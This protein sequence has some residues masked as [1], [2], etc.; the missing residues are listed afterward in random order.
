[1]SKIKINFKQ[2]KYVIP[3]L[4]YLPLLA[5]V[6]FV[7]DAFSGG[8]GEVVDTSLE[9]TDYYNDKLPAAHVDDIG[10]KRGNMEKAFQGLR[11]RTAVT[12]DGV[13]QALGEG[14]QTQYTEAQID[15]MNREEA[16][17]KRS[18]EAA[19]DAARLAE[20]Q[21]KARV[22]GREAVL[23][24]PDPASSL[25]EEDRVRRS[26]ASRQAMFD[27]LEQELGHV[28]STS[29]ANVLADYR[30]R[31]GL[32]AGS[33]LPVVDPTVDSPAADSL[34]AAVQQAL[35]PR[36]G[37]YGTDTDGAVVAPGDDVKGAV[38][39]KQ[40]SGISDRFNTIVSDAG[41]DRLI[42]AIID[43]E[44]K[45]VDGSRVR[46][47]L[48]DDA[49]VGSLHLK[50]GTCLYAL[51]S[52]FSKQRIQGRVE[53]ILLRDEIVK[54]SLSLY[55]LD[56]L[57]GL[58]VPESSF[59]ETTKDV[60]GGALSGGNLNLSSM[61]G[62]GGAGLASMG[63]QAAQSAYQQAQQAIAKAI[64]KNKVR[65]KYGTHVY[66]VNSSK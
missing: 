64:K 8:G 43:E 51:L 6:W 9:T 17:R 23:D 53:S 49:V 2:P 30:R 62:L 58:Y 50:K 28:D 10:D 20:E 39:S 14:Y 55:D 36:R 24:D 61:G 63:L 25:S 56:G 21:A 27:R 22:D 13:D 7:L 66:L 38:V 15:S 44:L 34:A 11:E 12:D 35:S 48:L 5:I 19:R 40:R 45:V 52:G 46:L 4:V 31:L 3:A 18:A 26:L 47:R 65:L 32:P 29:T 33:P 54:V 37:F 42:R 60:A 57:S 41:E 59:R 16:E 1:M